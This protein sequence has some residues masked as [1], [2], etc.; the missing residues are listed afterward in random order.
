[1]LFCLGILTLASFG[2]GDDQDKYLLLC[3]IGRTNA[4]SSY[5]VTFRSY[6]TELKLPCLVRKT[7][8]TAIGTVHL[9]STCFSVG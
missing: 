4:T 3:M 6:C 8:L 9:S 2:W 7:V 1:M 5:L